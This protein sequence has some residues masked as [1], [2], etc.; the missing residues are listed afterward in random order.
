VLFLAFLLAGPGAFVS[1]KACAPCHSEIYQA[2]SGTAHSRAL[3][4]ASVDAPVRADWAFGAGAQAVTYVSRI[5]EDSYLEHPLSFYSKSKTL[6]RTPGHQEGS[7]GVRY[8]MFAPDAAILRCF[9]CHSTGTLQLQPSRT[10][11][12]YEAGV[13]CESCHGPGEAHVRAPSKANISNPR[14]LSGA[15]MNEDCG[16]CHR[17]PPA[18]GVAT[19][20]ENAWNVRHQPVYL[21]QSRC[22]LESNGRLRCTSCHD[23]HRDAMPDVQ[24][25]CA[26]CHSDVKHGAVRIARNKCTDCHMPAVQPQQELSFTNHWIGVYRAPLSTASN[27]LRPLAQRTRGGVAPAAIQKSR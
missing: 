26:G 20:W 10:I 24:A 17:M 12:P 15:E 9:G 23:P 11:R 5:D 3:A 6:G 2:Q 1:S 27:R 14:L 22:F 19:N 8:R 25:V 13:R 16:T 7:S 18:A 4:A 21:S